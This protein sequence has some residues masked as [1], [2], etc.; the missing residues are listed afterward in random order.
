MHLAGRTRSV[1]RL[2]YKQRDYPM[3]P[4]IGV[5][6]AIAALLLGVVLDRMLV[7]RL[8]TS[9]LERARME[10][11]KLLADAARDIERERHEKID[12]AEVA[13]SQREDTLTRENAETKRKFKNLLI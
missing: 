9:R 3:D 11:D 12:K 1:H 4:L 10:A 2:Q 13:L 8:A 5:A 6:I 7:N